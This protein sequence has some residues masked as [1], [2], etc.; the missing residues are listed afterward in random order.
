MF[1]ADLASV[2]LTMAIDPLL[3]LAI[4]SGKVAVVSHHVR[5]G[6]DVNCVDPAG[7]SPLMLAA[8]R[9]H[10]DVCTL[11]LEAGADSRTRD[12][13]GFDAETVAQAGGHVACADAIKAFRIKLEPPVVAPPTVVDEDNDE[14]S[15]GEWVVDEPV[16][17]PPVDTNY[18]AELVGAQAQIT[19]H[20]PIDHTSRW[21]DIELELPD[22]IELVRTRR[23]VRLDE[24]LG[25][26]RRLLCEARLTGRVDE[27]A[28]EQMVSGLPADLTQLQSERLELERG[29]SSDAT[30]LYEQRESLVATVR[31]AVL[32]M[33][34]SLEPREFWTQ[35]GLDSEIS[36]SDDEDIDDVLELAVCLEPRDEDELLAIYEAEVA[37][38]R[39]LSGNDEDELALRMADALER[40]IGV[41]AES[42]VALETL[43]G[44]SQD[45]EPAGRG[46]GE[47]ADDD[48]DVLEELGPD[49][50]LPVIASARR[51]LKTASGS[52]E[53]R[54][55]IKVMRASDTVWSQLNGVMDELESTSMANRIR[56]S[57]Q[58]ELASALTARRRLVEANLHL[59]LEMALRYR[60]RGLSALD[61][62]QEGAL[63]LLKAVARFDPE[64]G[65]ALGNYA[66]WWIRA[67]LDRAL[68]NQGLLVRIPVHRH[69]LL[70]KIAAARR[71]LWH[72][73]GGDPDP[74]MI[75]RY[76]AD[77]S[78]DADASRIIVGRP[79]GHITAEKVTSILVFE[80]TTVALDSIDEAA[81]AEA[82]ENKPLSPEEQLF[83][84]ELRA[85]VDHALS[86]LVPGQ[87]EII[88]LRFGLR[89]RE[90]HTL[91]EIGGLYDVTRERIRQREK[92]ALGDLRHPSR[93]R[94]LSVYYGEGMQPP[95]DEETIDE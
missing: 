37:Q 9:G 16:P 80:T 90:E 11:L 50:S 2:R 95:S 93:S 76:I 34:A 88:K 63:G 31:R 10:V 77:E 82:Q 22:P 75:A 8:G 32:D 44:Q 65:S 41:V 71:A 91:E 1:E 33:G 45:G 61:L 28:I 4:L 29:S 27:V 40:A 24:V 62:V 55:F 60:N 66:T 25:G 3:R 83:E 85:Q 17:P 72:Q 73:L 49:R 69:E 51:A 30:S 35:C 38:A 15:L 64:R 6:I 36:D 14:W 13:I 86:T 89:D 52:L 39:K 26:L 79:G 70:G 18:L 78:I 56:T 5:R 47:S 92:K 87:A 12:A 46:D 58:T 53:R 7:R 54:A 20:R 81:L 21:D 74:E 42:D 84:L 68:C 57:L 23:Q 43:S 67:A 59:V 48:D 19:R 94:Q